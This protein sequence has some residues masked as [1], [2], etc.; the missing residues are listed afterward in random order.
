MLQLT[1]PDF[2]ILYGLT[3]TNLSILP[4]RAIAAGTIAGQ[5]DG[6]GPFRFVSWS[7]GTSLTLAKNPDYW[8]GAPSISKIVFRTIPDEQ[9]IASALQAGTA[10]MGLL[11]QPQV[12]RTLSGTSLQ[13]AKELDL[14]YRALMLQDRTGPLANADARLAI[15][16]ALNRTDILANAALG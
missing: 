14:N 2:S 16:C 15:Q 10:Q 9:S 12:V 6:T 13:V 4:A 11:T 7:P 3:T 8:G 1:H 5:P